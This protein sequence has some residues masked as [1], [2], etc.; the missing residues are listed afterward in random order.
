MVADS[1]DMD[2]TGSGEF[3]AASRSADVTFTSTNTATI[4]ATEDITFTSNGNT[5]DAGIF[6]EAPL[7]DYIVPDALNF[8]AEAGN[9]ELDTGAV[10]LTVDDLE[11]GAGGIGGITI[12]AGPLFDAN[13]VDINTQTSAGRIYYE[14]G[15]SFDVTAGDNIVMTAN[16]FDG[17]INFLSTGDVTFEALDNLFIGAEE[18]A[19]TRFGEGLILFESDADIELNAEAL[20]IR[21]EHDLRLSAASTATIV[22]GATLT[23]ASSLSST[24][25]GHT[26]LLFSAIAGLTLE[27][28]PVD[29]EVIFSTG[30][31]S[32]ASLGAT[33]TW[34]AGDDISLLAS[35][36]S[37]IS[38]TGTS[39]FS[40]ASSILMQAGTDLS[41]TA[42]VG[43]VAFDA[44]ASTAGLRVENSDAGSEIEVESA[45][46]SYTASGDMEFHA[47][48]HIYAEISV[49]T[50]TAEADILSSNDVW[51]RSSALAFVVGADATF[52][53]Q[54][55]GNYLVETATHNINA[56]TDV[57]FDSHG[58]LG[59]LGGRYVADNNVLASV[60]GPDQLAAISNNINA[61]EVHSVSAD[62]ELVAINDIFIESHGGSI[63]I[64]SQNDIHYALST[65]S[66]NL[67]FYGILETLP[68]AGRFQ[69][70]GFAQEGDYCQ[71]LGVTDRCNTNNAGTSCTVDCTFTSGAINDIGE[72]LV[73]YG[74]AGCDGVASD[75]CCVFPNC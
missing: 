33:E 46:V 58:N 70:I 39:V 36:T 63:E 30:E 31:L 54:G 24:V 2:A 41:L 28:N 49:F 5:E 19:S 65:A 16:H 55:S 6:L 15:D 34:T 27:T 71:S 4:R 62:V 51:M 69:Q 64:R 56:A 44:S 25:H 66:G 20:D 8:V 26:S 60:Y 18:D 53:T 1:I 48:D 42:G 7:I 21:S 75:F 12:D 17:H 67:G 37:T 52:G 14:S 23:V 45:Q 61:I 3:L 68:A 74:L 59:G 29:S 32:L 9:V 50:S 57:V 10:T 72:M 11:L 13:F 22:S 38:S 35:T 47:G 40:S 43:A 73:A